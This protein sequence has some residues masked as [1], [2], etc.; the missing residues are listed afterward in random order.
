MRTLNILLT[1][2]VLCQPA[3]YRTPSAAAVGQFQ[4]GR[5]RQQGGHAAAA[6]RLS[7]QLHGAKHGARATHRRRHPGGHVRGQQRAV[8]S[9]QFAGATC[10]DAGGGMGVCADRGGRTAGGQATRA[11]YARC[12]VAVPPALVLRTTSGSKSGRPATKYGWPYSTMHPA[13]VFICSECGRWPG[14]AL[15]RRA[16][17]RRLWRAPKT[18]LHHRPK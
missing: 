13:A 15:E 7:R 16:R 5:R 8:H 1:R 14:C 17:R 3:S 12:K 18:Y 2:R 10:V 6:Q 4:R 9:A 11:R